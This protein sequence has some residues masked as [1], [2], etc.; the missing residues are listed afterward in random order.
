MPVQEAVAS[1]VWVHGVQEGG[2]VKKGGGRRKGAQGER[3]VVA[4]AVK[5]GFTR[6]HRTAPMQAGRPK[7]YPDVSGV[8]QLWLEVKCYG[9]NVPAGMVR[10]ALATEHPGYV[11]AV[12]WKTNRQPWRVTLDLEDLLALLARPRNDVELT[13]LPGADM[14][15]VQKPGD[16]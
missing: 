16:A 2:R 9:E 7:D 6:A 8:G 4:L 13:A 14:V 15:L 1:G 11:N 5:Y 10:E 12:A 3:E